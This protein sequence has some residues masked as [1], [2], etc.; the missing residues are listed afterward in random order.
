MFRGMASKFFFKP[1]VTIPVYPIITGIIIHLM[2]HIRCISVHKLVTSL[3]SVIFCVTFLSG[4]ITTS[5]SIH[6]FPLSVLNYIWPYLL[7]LH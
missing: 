4:G 2:F 5:I 7:S 1:S 6:V 3:F